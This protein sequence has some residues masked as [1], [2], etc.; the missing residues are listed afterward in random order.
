MGNSADLIT[1][2]DFLKVD[3]RVGTIVSVEEFPEAHKPAIKLFIDFGE[4]FGI[5]KS[6]AQITE[7]YSATDLTGR[8]VLAVVNFPPV[9]WRESPA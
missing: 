3:I 2:D 6:S 5:K 4:K 9:E 1:I 8:Q 7:N